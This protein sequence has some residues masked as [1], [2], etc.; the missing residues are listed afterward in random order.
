MSYP[1]MPQD[2]KLYPEDPVL[3]SAS[4]HRTVKHFLPCAR[5][6]L[7]AAGSDCALEHRAGVEQ[8]LAKQEPL[9]DRKGRRL[10]LPLW[11]EE[12]ILAVVIL[13]EGDSALFEA[14]VPWLVERIKLV[15]RELQLVKQMVIDPALGLPNC[16]HLLDELADLVTCVDLAQSADRPPQTLIL[17]ELYPVARDVEQSLEFLSRAAAC[18][19]TL[20]K[21][22]PLHHLGMGVF[23][24]IWDGVHQAQAEKSIDAV[25]HWLKRENFGRVHIAIAP[26][27]LRGQTEGQVLE[28]AW[29]ALGLARKRGS[30]ASC[31][32][33]VLNRRESHP[34]KPLPPD[35]LAELSRD[36]RGMNRFALVLLRHDQEP[37][38]DFSLPGIEL[39]IHPLSS[40]E[41]Y[42]VLAN[43]DSDKAL[44][45]ARQVRDQAAQ[46]HNGTFSMGI[47]CY[48]CQGFRKADIPL[49]A[50]KALL[51][52]EFF[53]PDSMTLF[54]SV[55]LNI[56][57][58]I[59]FNEGDLSAAAVE[60]RK[61]LV[62]N[63]QN[64]NLLN[65][66][67]V[68]CAHMGRYRE[69]VRYFE[70]ILAVAPRD[71]MALFNLGFAHLTLAEYD[72]AI[73]RFE[74]AYTIDQEN[75]DLILHLGRLY[76]L[77]SRFA[78]AVAILL[79]GE[80]MG[81]SGRRDV[82]QGALERHLGEA[83]KALGEN[84]KAM[85][86]LER[87]SRY[88]PRDTAALSLLGEL[89]DVEKQGPEIALSLC[90]QA[91]KLDNSQWE[92]WYRLGLVQ[93]RQEDWAAATASLRQSLALNRR[94]VAALY[95]SGGIA[96]KTG[97][98]GD[99]R[100]IYRRVLALDP[101]HIEAKA[102]LARMAV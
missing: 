76:C 22:S 81:E 77:T 62:L 29:Q 96:E 33:M 41:A 68:C 14:S 44:S 74:L 61:G 23:A 36:W 99:A 89:Y 60:Y 82:G 28:D 32:T 64:V 38:G 37:K 49:N 12:E 102:A 31:S 63:G 53:G 91:V 80:K 92:Y 51:H 42:V 34:L 13:E 20:V 52:T 57:G 55:S 6:I 17:V 16:R 67:G 46:E 101:G 50:R 58:D 75:F 66:V 85:I 1:M 35:F 98:S 100:R 26:V 24:F 47:A 69:A 18:L 73:H 90:R 39:P 4:F 88:N 72:Q 87:A 3:L 27:G 48:P 59:Y 30:F 9:V 65:S 10:F 15:A 84:R 5:V 11:Q 8:A 2:M 25:L 78:E 43:A 86:C 79:K 70:R 94:G 97:K 56:S 95:L 40:R 83:Y 45:W 7:V 19:T 21:K 71:F 54:D 93:F